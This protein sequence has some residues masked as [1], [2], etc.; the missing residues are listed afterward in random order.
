MSLLSTLPSAAEMFHALVARDAAY[1]GVFFAA[2][3]TT[4]I[5]CRPTCAAR[6]PRPENVE[7]FASADDAR[8]AGYRP[9]ARCAP[10]RAPGETPSWLRPVLERVDR[11]PSRR[12][13]D[14]DLAALDVDPRRVRRWFL[15]NH[16]TTFHAWQRARRVGLALGR[17]GRGAD[18]TRVAYDHGWESTS[19]FRDAFGRL[20]GS[21]PGRSRAVGRLVISRLLTPLGPMLAGAVDEGLCLLEFADGRRVERQLRRVKRA[22][23]CA[24]AP[25]EHGHIARVR[26]E[27]DRY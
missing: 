14:V 6:K 19:A 12:W 10:T 27:L 21:P 17:I 1:E 2:V 3:R 11:D 15:S 8:A 20:V 13:T 26:D 7:F 25:G 5:F 16:R 22:L 4:G 18:L 24:V 23:D 9:C